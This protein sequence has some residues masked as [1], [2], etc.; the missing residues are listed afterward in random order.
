VKE[1]SL[2]LQLNEPKSEKLL[3]DYI[4][5]HYYGYLNVFTEKEAINLPLHWPWNY[6]VKLTPNALP[7]IAYRAFP[8]SYRKEEF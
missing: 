3:K 4:L 5:E 2:L 8:L 6:T 1:Q 7:L